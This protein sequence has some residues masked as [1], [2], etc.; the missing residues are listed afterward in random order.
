MKYITIYENTKTYL[1]PNMK[2]ATPEEVGMEY[3]AVNIEGIKC[4]IETD[5]SGIMFYTAP[6]PIQVMAG[7]IG[8]DISGCV[9]DEERLQIISDILNAPAPES[10][11]SAEERIAAALEYQNLLSM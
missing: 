6:E 10:E 2:T 9:T 3:S 4:V 1:Y 5:E 7:R 11:P 8:A